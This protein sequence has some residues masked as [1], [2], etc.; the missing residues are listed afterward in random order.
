MH[1]SWQCL[2]RGGGEA[3]EGRAF[4]LALAVV[5][6]VLLLQQQEWGHSSAWIRFRFPQR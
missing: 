2:I 4:S 1:A 3:V 5:A 6:A